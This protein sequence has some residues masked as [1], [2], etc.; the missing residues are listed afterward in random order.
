MQI[1]RDLQPPISARVNRSRSPSPAAR[2]N[3]S[4]SP[5]PAAR[6]NRSRSPSPAARVNRSRSPSASNSSRSRSP[7]PGPSN[8]QHNRRRRIRKFKVQR[9]PYLNWGNSRRELV[10]DYPPHRLTFHNDDKDFTVRR[11]PNKACSYLLS[12]CSKTHP[13]RRDTVPR[14][15][16]ISI[17]KRRL[18]I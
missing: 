17:K 1:V 5:S 6:V 2:V 11:I 9:S 15:A 4:R 3:R 16:V 10:Y 8:R 13:I 12:H 18:V 14:N 7:S